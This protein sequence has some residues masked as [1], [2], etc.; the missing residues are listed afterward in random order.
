MHHDVE[1]NEK[2]HYLK[3]DVK[4]F[5][6]SDAQRRHIVQTYTSMLEM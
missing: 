6:D 4:D 1:R 2:E 5:I 3:V